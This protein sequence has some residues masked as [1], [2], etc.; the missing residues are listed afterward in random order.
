MNKDIYDNFIIGD[1]EPKETLK[2]H[3]S[4]ILCSTVLKDGRF[5]V[6]SDD[7][8]IIIYNNKTFKPDLLLKNIIEQLLV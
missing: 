8:S 1:K 3:T 7:N 5:V 4:S 6:G 2:Y